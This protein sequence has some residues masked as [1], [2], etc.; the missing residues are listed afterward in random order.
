MSVG[1]YSPTVSAAYA[2][3]Q[4]WWERNGGEDPANKGNEEYF[5]DRDGYD[6]YGYDSLGKDRAGNSEDEYLLTSEWQ[7]DELVYTL[8]DDIGSRWGVGENDF[9]QSTVY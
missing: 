5:F 8:F 9:P 7:G 1:K 6:S 2:K 3:D 4:D